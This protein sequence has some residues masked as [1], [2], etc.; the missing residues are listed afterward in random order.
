M[1]DE[2]DSDDVASQKRAAPA[3]RD[4]CM[5]EARIAD[6][7]RLA[8]FRAGDEWACGR[9]RGGRVRALAISHAGALAFPANGPTPRGWM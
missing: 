3:R 1:T 8:E 7:S 4:G 9:L 5:T 2:A 6:V